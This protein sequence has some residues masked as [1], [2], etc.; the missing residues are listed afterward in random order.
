MS[1]QHYRKEFKDL[2]EQTIIPE[3]S[4]QEELEK[5]LMPLVSL[6]LKHIPARL[7]KYRECS[8]KDFEAFNENKLYAS[9]SDKFNDPFD[10]LFHYDKK[11]IL[12]SLLFSS[13]KQYNVELRDRLRMGEEF[14]LV[15]QSLFSKDYLNAFKDFL[16]NVSDEELEK[17]EKFMIDSKSAW[18]ERIERVAEEAIS[19]V[20]NLSNIACLSEVINS[21]TMWSH[22]AESH[23]GFAL[24]YD[25]RRF[26]LKEHLCEEIEQNNSSLQGF[27]YPV[28]YSK[29]RYDATIYIDWAL[30]KKG[31]MPVLNY[32]ILT[33]IKSQLYKSLQWS[34]EKE[35]RLIISS[36][37][38]N[39]AKP[40]RCICNL[41]PTAIY[42]GA[43]IK[44]INKKI[45]HSMAQ[46][47]GIDEYQMYI[48]NDSYNY[49]IR[50]KKL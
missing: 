46:E 34:Y 9:I 4:T 30:G 48:D 2:L 21:V 45:L 43:R 11:S 50:Y 26:N 29:Q 18:E 22:Y 19:G 17:H 39:Q 24:A 14:P 20:K 33:T 3:G 49:S 7:F 23:K 38:V 6:I 8:E 10:C 40:T 5:K 15:Y 16:I 27:L 35:W 47:K 1:V 31:N 12:H 37:T 36:T 41:S 32:D 13:T 42:Y 25:F 44:P 28:I